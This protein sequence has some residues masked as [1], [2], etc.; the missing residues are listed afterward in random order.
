MGWGGNWPPWPIKW[1]ENEDTDKI[2]IGAF[3]LAS[4][5]RGFREEKLKVH[6]RTLLQLS[7]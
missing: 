5:A 4:P 1:K 2:R 6:M 7:S 3:I